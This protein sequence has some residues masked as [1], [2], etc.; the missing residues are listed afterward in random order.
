MVNVKNVK[1]KKAKDQKV[2]NETCYDCGCLIKFEGDNIKNG[3]Y[4][5]YQDG[6]QKISVLKCKSCY[7]KNPGLTNFRNCE[8]YSRVVGYLRPVQQ[9]NDGKQ[10]EYQKRKEY[11]IKNL[12]KKQKTNNPCGCSQ[13]CREF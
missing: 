8:V 11:K 10:L 6:S 9:W 1:I 12:V 13:A 7:Q 4:L 2:K 3:H 5:V